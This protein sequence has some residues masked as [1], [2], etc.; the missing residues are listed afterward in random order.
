MDDYLFIALAK[1][2]ADARKLERE[3]AAQSA[4]TEE[5]ERT[6]PQTHKS[7]RARQFVPDADL[8]AIVST[9]GLRGW[10]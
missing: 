2:K 4:V 3:R 6:E 9:H 5:S 7:R 1:L 8:S 10:S